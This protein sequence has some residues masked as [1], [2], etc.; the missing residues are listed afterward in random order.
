MRNK[1]HDLKTMT[2]RFPL[3]RHPNQNYCCYLGIEAVPYMGPD[4]VG[5]I[6]LNDGRSIG[7][8]QHAAFN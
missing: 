8:F 6:L 5:F 7:S 2:P 1:L 4:G 3:F